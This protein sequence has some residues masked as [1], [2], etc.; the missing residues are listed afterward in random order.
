MAPICALRLAGS[1]VDI[2]VSE[3]DVHD[4]ALLRRWYAVQHAAWVH[5]RQHP[6]THT[7]QEPC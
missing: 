2:R 7:Y 6:V 4:D 3:I 1:M 5:G